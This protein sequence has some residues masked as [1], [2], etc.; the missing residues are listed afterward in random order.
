M[1]VVVE[2]DLLLICFVIRCFLFCR[3]VS[4]VFM[5]EWLRFKLVFS[6]DLIFM[7][8]YDLMLCDMNCSDI[9]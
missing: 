1:I 6:V 2:V 7:L 8:N 9:R 4:V 5:V 3:L